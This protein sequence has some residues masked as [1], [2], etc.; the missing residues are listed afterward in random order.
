MKKIDKIKE[1]FMK[2]TILDMGGCYVNFPDGPGARYTFTFWKDL[3]D[4]KTFGLE[5]IVCLKKENTSY[6]ID[7]LSP[8]RRYQ[9]IGDYTK[10]FNLAENIELQY[11]G[12]TYVHSENPKQFTC[13]HKQ[14][15]FE[16]GRKN[17]Q[18]YFKFWHEQLIKNPQYT[19]QIKIRLIHEKELLNYINEKEKK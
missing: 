9:K 6:L 18:K 5:F 12:G 16:T 14:I 7:F 10:G 13:P 1:Y 17:I 4:P 15:H 8:K 19:K 2:N 3:N 11:N